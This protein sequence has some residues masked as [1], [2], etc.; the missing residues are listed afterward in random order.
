[1]KMAIEEAKRG[2]EA[3]EGGPF[4]AVIVKDGEVVA[5]GHNEVVKTNDPTAHAEI[6]AIRRASRILNAFHLEGCVLFV[7]GEPCP[8][9][10]A[11]IHWAHIEKVVYCNTKADAAAIGFDDA[12]ITEI[13]LGKRSDPVLFEHRPDATCQRLFKRWYENPDKVLY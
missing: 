5:K 10:F 7:T 6:I 13:I 9:C 4:G 2:I 1:M 3:G 11:A 8:M 12:F